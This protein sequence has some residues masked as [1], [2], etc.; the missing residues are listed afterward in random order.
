M[1]QGMGAAGLTSVSGV[2][3]VKVNGMP[4][5]EMDLAEFKKQYP[6]RPELK[7]FT[8]GPFLPKKLV[9]VAGAEGVRTKPLKL[10]GAN[11]FVQYVA[12]GGEVPLTFTVD[13]IRGLPH[14]GVTVKDSTG[15]VVDE[16]KLTP[17]KTTYRLRSNNGGAH[18]FALREFTASLTI[19]SDAPGQ[20]FVAGAERLSMFRCNSE[21]FFI[22]PA[23]AK[24]VKIELYADEPAGGALIDADGKIRDQVKRI[25]NGI[26][27]L[28]AKRRPSAEPEIWSVKLFNVSEDHG[29]RL[30][31]PLSPIVST[32]P[33]NCLISQED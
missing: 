18:T 19:E 22:V 9:A 1:V 5:Q 25:E 20:G 3:S 16:L 13:P 32:S 30:G 6:P 7:S 2:L 14:V 26:K 29:I 8:T 23:G 4:V 31:A 15:I 24:E 10:R 21:L 28:Y 11:T 27:I 12:P 17:G 33:A